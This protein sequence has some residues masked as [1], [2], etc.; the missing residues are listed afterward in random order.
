MLPE[1]PVQHQMRLVRT[2]DSGAEEWFC[3]VCGRRFLMHWPPNYKKIILEA[4]D[5]NAHHSGTKG[6]FQM[7][8]LVIK[9]GEPH[10]EQWGEL[11][12]ETKGPSESCSGG[13]ISTDQI[14][15]VVL[16]ED[17]KARL[18][19][20]EKWMEQSNFDSLWIDKD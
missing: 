3:P 12:Q 15:G 1:Q 17:D 5:E 11:E 2:H 16:T 13:E 7:N 9:P 10:R 4:G 18:I 14:K 20:W 6:G 8:S 19:L